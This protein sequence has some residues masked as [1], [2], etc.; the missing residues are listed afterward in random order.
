MRQISVGSKGE[1]GTRYGDIPGPADGAEFFAA[2]TECAVILS[3]EVAVAVAKRY[4]NIATQGFHELQE[5]QK[6]SF[7]AQGQKG[8]TAENIVPA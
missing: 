3:N 2:L 6:V 8:P 7:G 4:S 1:L 5:G